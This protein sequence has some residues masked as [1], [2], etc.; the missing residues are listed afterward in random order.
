MSL[1]K[2]DQDDLILGS[3]SCAS[4]GVP[5]CCPNIFADNSYPISVTVPLR[6][7][8]VTLAA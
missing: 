7:S 8:K 1:S 6:N 3:H 2:F 4:G 5:Y